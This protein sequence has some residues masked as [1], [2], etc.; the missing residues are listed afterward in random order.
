MYPSSRFLFHPGTLPP[1]HHR[2]RRDEHSLIYRNVP[3]NRPLPLDLELVNEEGRVR[4]DSGAA[5]STMLLLTVPRTCNTVPSLDGG[6]LTSRWWFERDYGGSDPF[7]DFISIC[8]FRIG[9]S[10]KTGE[11]LTR[12]GLVQRFSDRAIPVGDTLHYSR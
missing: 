4:F 10:S 6:T 3:N 1:Q 5:R 8:R 11:P 9:S 2:L 12:R 7:D